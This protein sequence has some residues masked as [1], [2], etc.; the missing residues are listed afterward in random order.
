M[1]LIEVKEIKKKKYKGLVYDLTINEQHSYNIDGIIVHNSACITAS[2]TSIHYPMA[3]LIKECYEISLSLDNP[4]KIIADGGVK[5]FSDVIKCLALGADYVMCGSIFNKMLESSGETTVI[6]SNLYIYNVDEIVNQFDPIVKR[7][8][9]KGDVK[10]SKKYYGMSTRKAQAEINGISTKTSEG[11]EKTFDVEY[12]MPQWVENFS[13]YLK[14][15]MSYTSRSEIEKFV[16][17]VDTIV[18][19]NNSYNSVN[20]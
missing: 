8:F 5:G 9:D 7:W 19:S 14:S 6:S 1:K 17:N 10:L 12:T 4:A 11:I 15:A 20:K 18:V 3:S 13:D 16:G 2:N